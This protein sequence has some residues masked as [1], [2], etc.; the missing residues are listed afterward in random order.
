[1][2]K[3]GSPTG[4][5]LALVGGVAVAFALPF[6]A[7]KGIVFL[8]GL[9]A[10]NIVFALCFNLLFST[11]GL[12]SFGQATFFAVGAYALGILTMRLPGMPFLLAL[13]A[14]GLAGALVAV[15]IGFLAL[16]RT[17][18]IYFAVL[19]LAFGEVVRIVIS[20]TTFLG[21]NDG[22]TG[23]PRPRIGLG[24]ATLDLVQGDRYYYFLVLLCAA[25][26][27]VIWWVTYSRYGRALRAIKQEPLRA[28]FL[29]IDV[30]R[31]RLLAYAISGTVTALAGAA[32][33]PWAQIVTPD[34]AHWSQSTRPVLFTLLGGAGY[35]WGP[36]VGAIVFSIVEYGTRTM[37]GASDLVTG[38]LL[39][40]VVLAVPG[41]ICGIV[42]LTLRS[43]RG[44]RV[45][46][47][48]E[49]VP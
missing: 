22:I 31:H 36:A 17:E 45:P 16:R 30:R 4:L 44:R 15:V 9:V 49:A 32:F 10:V 18:G 2:M 38:G 11:S 26:C 13:A 42:A 33:A 46:A 27:A 7:N 12:L 48:V 14:A 37:Q 47:R 43:L 3:P 25:L 20:K 19:T 6:V 28:D 39:L 5:W 40:A 21:R 24:L 23:I 1:M 8:A 29:G 35:F 34:L 41:G